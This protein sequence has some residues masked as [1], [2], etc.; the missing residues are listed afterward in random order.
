[1]TEGGRQ[2]RLV[3]V[4]WR[5]LPYNGSNVR[6]I[7]NICDT[8]WNVKTTMRKRMG[9]PHTRTD[10][11]VPRGSAAAAL[12]LK[13]EHARGPTPL[14]ASPSFS[15]D[16]GRLSRR[17]GWLP[18][19]RPQMRPPKGINFQVQFLSRKTRYLPPNLGSWTHFLGAPWGVPKTT[20]ES[21]IDSLFQ[22]WPN[23]RC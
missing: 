21:I 6:S 19:I 8:K 11:P 2:T 14:G 13:C 1:M 17:P 23:T 9:R 15:Y 12:A 3:C 16:G 7:G 4:C 20:P 22:F 5:V 18:N 10:P